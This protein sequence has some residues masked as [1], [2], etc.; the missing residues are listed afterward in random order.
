MTAQRRR[1]AMS[2]TRKW[3]RRKFYVM[4]ALLVGV[5]ALL[6]V[7]AITRVIESM[8]SFEPGLKDFTRV[9]PPRPH[10][11]TALFTGTEAYLSI[12]FLVLCALFFMQSRKD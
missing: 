9:E 12:A 5:V 4:T 3:S 10:G 7:P 6:A 11:L 2:T 1:R 8:L